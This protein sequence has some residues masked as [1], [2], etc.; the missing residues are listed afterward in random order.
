VNGS[1]SV[2]SLF[3]RGAAAV[4]SPAAFP[5]LAVGLAVLSYQ[6]CVTV[7]GLRFPVPWPDEASFLWPALGFRDHFSLYAP[8]VN[9]EREVLWMPPGFMVLYG[10]VFSVVPFTLERARIVSTILVMVAVLSVYGLVHRLRARAAHA[11]ALCAL[12]T[13]PIVFMAGNCARMESLVLALV[14][15][16]FFLLSRGRAAGFGVVAL[17]PLVHPNGLFALTGAFVYAVILLARRRRPPEP[18]VTALSFRAAD[19]ALLGAAALAWVAYAVH[20]ARHFAAFKADMEA[21]LRFKLLVSYGEDDVVARLTAWPTVVGLLALV[22]GGVLGRRLKAPIL[23]LF[24]LS[25]SLFVQT[26]VAAGWLYEVY[27]A[28][29]LTLTTIM[30]VESLWLALE[31]NESGRVLIAARVVLGSAA[32]AML[33]VA[34]QGRFL[35]RSLEKSVVFR[36]TLDPPYLV[37]EDR[38]M[39][40][41]A[42]RQLVRERGRVTVQF[43]PSGEGLAYESERGLDVAFVEQTFY[44]NKLDVLM[45][46]ESVWSPRAVNDLELLHALNIMPQ[47]I[48][49]P[50]TFHSRD[51][52]EK[53]SV[54]IAGT[55]PVPPIFPSE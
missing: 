9:P 12:L 5:A 40:R 11:A 14:T 13:F 26:A 52:T 44:E 39:V 55:G 10:L 34:G 31:R 45:V 42:I 38:R 49:K 19:F 53:W 27:P 37:R 47:P 54:Y 48:R 36:D 22:A 6:V 25:V 29:A 30:L 33:F 32:V 3:L 17:A 20:I 18:G 35:T 28:L 51:G 41:G 21:Q 16:G 50:I 8:E 7:T 23:G 43:I 15:V 1:A 4:R 24:I 2:K 46:H